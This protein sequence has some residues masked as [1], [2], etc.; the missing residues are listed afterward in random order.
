MQ[1]A[2]AEQPGQ[3]VLDWT[4]ALVG[5][6]LAAGYDGIPGDEIRLAAMCRCHILLWRFLLT[7][8]DDF[9]TFHRELSRL[10]AL[11]RIDER[12]LAALNRQVVA[13]LLDTIAQRYTRSPREAGRQ[14]FEVTRAACR[15]AEAAG[16]LAA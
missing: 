9:G 16:R 8:R 11:C 15:L 10:A 13:E 5:D 12:T 7:G 3:G 6:V 1:P 14:S 2:H 4:H